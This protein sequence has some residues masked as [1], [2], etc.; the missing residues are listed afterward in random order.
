MIE[1]GLVALAISF[2]PPNNSTSLSSFLLMVSLIILL[3]LFK[4]CISYIKV[5]LDFTLSKLRY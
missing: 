4:S 2:P 3:C 1:D 5:S